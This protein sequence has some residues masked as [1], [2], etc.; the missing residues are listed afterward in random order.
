MGSAQAAVAPI[1]CRTT[2]TGIG[3]MAWRCFGVPGPSMPAWRE[4]EVNHGI[5]RGQTGQRSSTSADSEFSNHIELGQVTL[6]SGS[7]VHSPDHLLTA[8]KGSRTQLA[9]IDA[10]LRH[11]VEYPA[12]ASLVGPMR[13]L[14]CKSEHATTCA[15]LTVP[16]S[17]FVHGMNDSM[18]GHRTELSS[19]QEARAEHRPFSRKRASDCG[20][21]PLPWIMDHSPAPSSELANSPASSDLSSLM[22]L[23]RATGYVRLTL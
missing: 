6:T 11:E 19:R 16:N 10:K 2:L 20:L 3:E 14:L 13:R 21:T 18:A 15:L 17:L 7:A 12:Q 8:S 22:P 4:G 1:R 9:S 23:A 5:M